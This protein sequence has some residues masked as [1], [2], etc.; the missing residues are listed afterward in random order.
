MSV[1]DIAP[2][3]PVVFFVWQG[4][5][6]GR[7]IASPTCIIAVNAASVGATI[8]RLFCISDRFVR[9]AVACCRRRLL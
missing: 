5:R 8:G 7:L 1:K 2:L 4:R 3:P 9:R 6:D